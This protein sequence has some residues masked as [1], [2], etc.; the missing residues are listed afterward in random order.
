VPSSIRLFILGALERGGPMYGHQIRRAAQIDRTELWTDFRQGSL[1]GALHRMAAE[2]VV[3]IVRTEQEGN[4]PARTVYQI[5]ETG[6]EELTAIRDRALRETQLTPDPVDLALQNVGDMSEDDLR[7]VMEQR[8]AAIAVDLATWRRLQD[9]AA[10]YLSPI[11]ALAFRHTLLR[12]EA[13]L[14]WHDE[15]IAGLPKVFGGSGS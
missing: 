13:E 6:R 14:A 12:V 10:P 7:S 8:R 5:T 1:Y 2:G 11:E 9:T 15:F 4:M 3:E